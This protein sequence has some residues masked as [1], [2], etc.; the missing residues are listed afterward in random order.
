M[1]PSHILALQSHLTPIADLKPQKEYLPAIIRLTPIKR[2]L[3]LLSNQRKLNQ[4]LPYPIT[5]QQFGAIFKSIRSDNILPVLSILSLDGRVK[6]ILRRWVI[7]EEFVKTNR[8]RDKQLIVLIM[9]VCFE[10]DVESWNDVR[11]IL[12][13][14]FDVDVLLLALLYLVDVVVVQ[15]RF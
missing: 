15:L 6:I 4:R 10:F 7:G 11:N 13:L 3:T 14:E 8:N 9:P 12:D 5:A 2:H 1:I